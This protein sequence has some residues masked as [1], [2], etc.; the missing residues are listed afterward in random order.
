MDSVAQD[1]PTSAR[2]SLKTASSQQAQT[3]QFNRLFDI[4]R[5]TEDGLQL[6]LRAEQLANL[7]VGQNI[8]LPLPNGLQFSGRVAERT[9]VVPGVST[10][11]IEGA[12]GRAIVS[13]S[14]QAQTI[15]ITAFNTNYRVA[16]R[17]GHFFLTVEQKPRLDGPE[18]DALIHPD[19]RPPLTN[20]QQAPLLQPRDEQATLEGETPVVDLFVLVDSKA[21]PTFGGDATIKVAEYVVGANLALQDSQV[22][23]KYNVLRVDQVAFDDVTSREALYSLSDDDS[24]ATYRQIAEGIGADILTALIERPQRD[25]NCGIAFVGGFDGSFY[26]SPEVSISGVNC[27]VSTFAHELGHN[28]GLAHSRAQGD[29]GYSYDFAVGHGEIAKFNTIMAYGSAYRGAS[30]YPE[31][32]LV[33]S[34]PDL[35]CLGSPCGIAH[36]DEPGVDN[37][38]SADAARAL[39]LV[40]EKASGILL[41]Q[42]DDE[43]NTLA[44]ATP[45]PEGEVTAAFDYVG[46]IDVFSASLSSQSVLSVAVN[47]PVTFAVMDAD[48]VT[49]WRETTDALSLQLPTGDYFIQLQSGDALGTGDYALNTSVQSGSSGNVTTTFRIAGEGGYSGITDLVS[50]DSCQLQ[51][52]ICELLSPADM[53]LVPQVDTDDFTRL[54]GFNDCDVLQPYGCLRLSGGIVDIEL[55][56]TP[57]YDLAGNDVGESKL[58]SWRLTHAESLEHKYDKDFYRFSATQN[59]SY[60]LWHSNLEDVKATVYDRQMERVAEQVLTSEHSEQG[61]AQWDIGYLAAGRYYIVLQPADPDSFENTYYWVNVTPSDGGGEVRIDISDSAIESFSYRLSPGITYRFYNEGGKR[62]LAYTAPVGSNVTSTVFAEDGKIARQLGCSSASSGACVVPVVAGITDISVEVLEDADSDGLADEWQ[63]QYGLTGGPEGDDDGDQ[64]ANS[65]EFLAAT[66]PTSADSDGDNISDQVEMRYGLNPNDRNDAF[67][68][69]DGDFIPTF[70]ELSYDTDPTSA[71]SRYS[72]SDTAVVARLGDRSQPVGTRHDYDGDGRADHAF[73]DPQTGRYYIESTGLGRN[74]LVETGVINGVPAP[75]DYDGDG[76]TDAAVMDPANGTWFIRNSL[77]AQSE[78]VWLGTRA[79]DIPVPADYD[80]DGKADPTI[81]RPSEGFWAIQRSSDAVREFVYFGKQATD[82]PMAADMNG[83]G[84]DDFIIRRPTTGD[85]YVKDAVTGDITQWF[86]GREAGD[87]PFVM[88]YN[89]DG[90]NEFAIRRPS[91]RNWFIKELASNDVTEIE[92]GQQVTDIPAIY[93][94]DGDGSDDLVIRR[95]NE[96]RFYWR[97]VFN[98]NGVDYSYFGKRDRYIPAAAPLIYRMP[99]VPWATIAEQQ[100]AVASSPRLDP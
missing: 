50:G 78:I 76:L 23:M 64:V 30:G 29:T 5:A 18:T 57:Y 48:G 39:N 8:T 54:K 72:V 19:R 66:D 35:D 13:R 51:D 6:T 77:T 83:D 43:G 45:L 71:G 10:L 95:A 20:K 63:Q 86:L 28:L 68:D 59:G 52:G 67:E 14:A 34:N 96:S 9:S 40:A 12:A 22:N 32:Q 75:A 91:N 88:D 99:G 58:L 15:L 47:T 80:G 25:T 4:K 38:D 44:N 53:P 27:G 11:I 79:E 26:G 93:D 87:I 56:L 7:T 81:R 84:Y 55:E 17:E 21:N 37:A 65:E 94:V 36:S 31:Q 42:Q 2:I 24:F 69:Q 70:F 3:D 73:Y 1:A 89:G 74:L 41:R 82:I 85:W 92:F 49:L 60:T 33:F 97:P 16:Q 90:I 62:Y 61:G 46:D 98:Y 100:T